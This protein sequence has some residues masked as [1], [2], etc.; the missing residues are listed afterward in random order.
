MRFL[1][2]WWTTGRQEGIGRIFQGP[3]KFIMDHDLEV[4]FIDPRSIEEV[5]RGVGV[6]KELVCESLFIGEDEGVPFAGHGYHRD[7]WV[8]VGRILVKGNLSLFAQSYF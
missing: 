5:G 3:L 7:V 6:W 8:A 2:A 4:L 1:S